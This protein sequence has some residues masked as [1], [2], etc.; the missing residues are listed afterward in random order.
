MMFY[1][2]ERIKRIFTWAWNTIASHNSISILLEHID[3]KRGF[4][5]HL[6]YFQ[7][8]VQIRFTSTGAFQMQRKGTASCLCFILRLKI[9][10]EH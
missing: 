9:S 4:I 10:S 5:K 3:N 2:K 1:T 8:N 6:F 7:S